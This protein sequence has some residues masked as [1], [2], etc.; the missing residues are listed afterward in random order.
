MTSRRWV[1]RRH[2]VCVFVLLCFCLKI[3]P[4]EMKENLVPERLGFSTI[5]LKVISC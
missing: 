3:K 2:C 4:Y 1:G 5:M